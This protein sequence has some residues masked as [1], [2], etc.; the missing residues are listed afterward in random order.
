MALTPE[1]VAK[2][3]EWATAPSRHWQ[4]LNRAK[5]KYQFRGSVIVRYVEEVKMDE[6]MVRMMLAYLTSDDCLPDLETYNQELTPVGE[7]KP[8]KA[9]YEMGNKKA[10][11]VR[12]VRLYH[13]M[14]SD[15]E[16]NVDGPYLVEDGCAYKVELEYHWNESSVP[17]VPA[18]SSGV[19]YRING[20]S[21]DQD[22]DLYSYTIEKRT[23]VQQDIE[24]Y[25]VST[26]IYRDT[27]EEKHIGVKQSA[28]ATTGRQ[29]SVNNGTMVHRK[30]SKN[31]D[32]TTDI[33]NDKTVDKPVR[34][35]QE[36]VTVSL[37]GAT[38]T[39]HNRNMHAPAAT[40]DLDVGESVT[41]EK[42]DSDLWN[43]TIRKHIRN[44]Y[45]WIHG[46]CTKTIYSHSHS[47]TIAQTEDPGFTH[48]EEASGGIIKTSDVSRTND[49]YHVTERTLRELPVASSSR[50]ASMSTHGLTLRVESRNQPA[51]L[52]ENGLKVGQSV[53]NRKTDGGLYDTVKTEAGN[54]PAGKVAE[55]CDWTFYKHDHNEVENVRAEDAADM[56]TPFEV[57]KLVNKSARIN[58]NGTANVSTSES[59]AVPRVNKYRTVDP[60]GNV[61]WTIKYHNQPD[62]PDYPLLNDGVNVDDSVNAYGLHDGVI[63]YTFGDAKGSS[64][65]GLLTWTKHGPKAKS[66]EFF[67]DKLGRVFARE[68]TTQTIWKRGKYEEYV[69]DSLD[70]NTGSG[71]TSIIDG[72]K[73]VKNLGR[74]QYG[75][76]YC[77]W[78]YTVKYKSAETF[79]VMSKR[80]LLTSGYHKVFNRGRL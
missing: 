36:T 31:Q 78:W 70:K 73:L 39:T 61:H 43:Q 8:T 4:I 26:T 15:P 9:W 69:N 66:V 74:D 49:G 13:A 1:E 75:N 58:D 3:R 37:T 67:T 40:D 80:K 63:R 30:L 46:V 21:H 52:P 34:K 76:E 38:V 33:D 41:N 50:T 47:E 16:E 64:G 7:Y 51:P 56:E 62:I 53:S 60:Y 68:F 12:S 32:C 79:D 10:S 65:R 6:G 35:A 57:G 45:M 28:V 55:G 44:F 25:L 2:C 54:E 20:I 19:S 72:P 23:R 5:W 71:D 22:T 14:S 18:S 17:P 42:T 11:E 59:T 24:E 29:A 77:E 27:Y 48:V